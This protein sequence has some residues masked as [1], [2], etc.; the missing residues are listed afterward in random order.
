[1]YPDN[2]CTVDIINIIF[3][4][5]FVNETNIFVNIPEIICIEVHAKHSIPITK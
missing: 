3:G 5:A 2:L 1:M 4:C